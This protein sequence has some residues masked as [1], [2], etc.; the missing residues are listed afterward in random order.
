MCID[1]TGIY[2]SKFFWVCIVL[3]I[4][5]FN[6]VPTFQNRGISI[7]KK[8]T[9]ILENTDVEVYIEIDHDKSKIMLTTRKSGEI[10]FYNMLDYENG[11][12]AC[13]VDYIDEN[14]ITCEVIDFNGDGIP[15]NKILNVKTN[16][17]RLFFIDCEFQEAE[18]K[19]DKILIDGKEIRFV[20]GRY[21]FIE[22]K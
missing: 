9:I 15:E 3:G 2:K 11:S 19:N 20:K 18:I 4:V 12:K 10:V 8:E 13:S 5:L 6:L 17:Q 21:I 7:D 22:E 1:S 14:G 16:P